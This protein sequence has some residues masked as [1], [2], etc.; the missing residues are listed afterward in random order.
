MVMDFRTYVLSGLTQSWDNA[1]TARKTLRRCSTDFG[2][3][4]GWTP[5]AAAVMGGES[6]AIQGWRATETTAC[7]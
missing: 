4:T 7:P 1:Q 5:V 6:G 3:G 2:P